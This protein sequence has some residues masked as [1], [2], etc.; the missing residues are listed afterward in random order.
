MKAAQ[1]YAKGDIRVVDVP[2]PVPDEH[3]ALVDIEWCGICGS[4]LHE[5]EYG[6]IGIPPPE[7]P[8]PATKQHLPV[9]MGHE[10][11]GRIVSHPPGFNLKPGQK[12]MVDPRI[13]CSKCSR[14]TVGSTHGCSTLGFK[15]LSGTGGGF[16]EAVAIDAKLCYPLPDDVDLSLAALIEPLAV[17]WHAISQC[18]VSDWSQT[19]ALILGG[20]PIGIACALGLRARGCKQIFISEPTTTRAAQNKQVADA[21]FN[22]IKDNVGDKCRELTG[23]EGVDVA[24]DCAGAQKGF[25]A[26]MDALRFRGTYMNVAAWGTPMVIPFLHYIM[27]EITTKCAFAY[28]D[29]DFKETVDA[30]VAGKFKGVETMITSR[31]YLDDIA[32]KGFEELVKR[33]DDHIKILV[34]PNK[35]I[36]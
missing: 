12:V 2:K 15:G 13:Y 8:H 28:D 16:S 26:G 17:A 14:C 21:V 19:R 20:G 36:V 27:K 10:F 6:P 23:G 9:T 34:T 31:I 33:K 18:D 25:D 24:F 1:Y 22:P 4:D 5:Y 7:R 3:E 32:Q 29:K 30:F 11:A 35:S